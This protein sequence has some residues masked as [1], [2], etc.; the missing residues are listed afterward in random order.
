MFL[1]L[2]WGKFFWVLWL[3]RALTFQW[4]YCIHICAQEIHRNISEEG[5]DLMKGC[6]REEFCIHAEKVKNS[7]ALHG[8][9][10]SQECLACPSLPVGRHG[11]TNSSTFSP[12]RINKPTTWSSSEIEWNWVGFVTTVAEHSWGQ[13]FCW[14]PRSQVL[15][16][17]LYKLAML[18]MPAQGCAQE[19]PKLCCLLLSTWCRWLLHELFINAHK[20]LSKGHFSSSVT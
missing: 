15:H 5:C 8:S 20:P 12:A 16:W 4:T 2:P 9:A 17:A 19:A 11:K 10:H 3:C 14:F 13:G 18:G 1:K 7:E 6:L